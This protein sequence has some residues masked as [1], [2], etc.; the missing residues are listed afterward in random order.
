MRLAQ[1]NDPG[2]D[3]TLH[4]KRRKGPWRLVYA[5][6]CPTRQAAMHRER[7]LKS[8]AGRRFIRGV[9]DVPSILKCR[10][11]ARTAVASVAWYAHDSQ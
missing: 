4:T 2:H 8:G 10:A 11:E 3:L 6:E 7:Q 1:H 5:E 9:L